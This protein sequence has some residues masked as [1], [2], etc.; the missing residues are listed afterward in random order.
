MAGSRKYVKY[1]TDAN[2]TY[3]V[4]IDESNAEACDFDDITIADEV[5]GTVPPPLPKGYKMRTGNFLGD[6]GSVRSIPIGK[7]TSLLITGAVLSVLLPVF[8][9]GSLFGQS[10]AFVL[11]S[12]IS[13]KFSVV[14]PSAKD[15]GLT[16]DDAT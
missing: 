15:S 7:P 5:A 2:V 4:N 14:R 12:I 9:S 8:Q 11:R 1:V 3:A 10:V 6:D 16:D 13:E